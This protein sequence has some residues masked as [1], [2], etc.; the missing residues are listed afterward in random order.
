MQGAEG[1]LVGTSGHAQRLDTVLEVVVYFSLHYVSTLHITPLIECDAS[2]NSLLCAS[3]TLMLRYH[4]IVT[5]VH[6]LSYKI[7]ADPSTPFFPNFIIHQIACPEI[8]LYSV[9]HQ[10]NITMATSDMQGQSAA[11]SSV[12]TDVQSRLSS[13]NIG[14]DVEEEMAMYMKVSSY[15]AGSEDLG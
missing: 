15:Y 7:W 14:E 6:R 5:H 3:T 4:I 12:V 11:E 10:Y 8:G 2:L 9:P 13:L 1:S